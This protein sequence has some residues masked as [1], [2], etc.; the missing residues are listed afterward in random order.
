MAKTQN[1]TKKEEC[2]EKRKLPWLLQ[3][4]WRDLE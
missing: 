2:K 3:A 4:G 1:K